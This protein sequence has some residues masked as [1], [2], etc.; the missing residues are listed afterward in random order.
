MLKQAQ[1]KAASQ[2]FPL[3]ILSEDSEIFLHA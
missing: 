3:G 1:I 2:L